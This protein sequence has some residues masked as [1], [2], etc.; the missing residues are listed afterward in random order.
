L[1]E[2]GRQNVPMGDAMA[3]TGHR[4]VP[5]FL[6]YFQTGAVQRTRA[7]TLLQSTESV[8]TADNARKSNS[9]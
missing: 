8:E 4:S 5:T 6:R 7:A 3:L 2:A 9:D 1:T